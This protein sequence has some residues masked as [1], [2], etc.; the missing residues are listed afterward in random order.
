VKRIRALH[1]KEKLVMVPRY[2]L[3]HPTL[4][5]EAIGI[6][7]IILSFQQSLISFSDRMLLPS[8]NDDSK[9]LKR[10]LAELEENEYIEIEE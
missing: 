2:L 4:S 1:D 5:P 3:N 6:F 8:C 7:V 9:K 10:I